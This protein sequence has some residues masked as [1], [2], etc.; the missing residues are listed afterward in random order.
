MKSPFWILILILLTLAIFGCAPLQPAESQDESPQEPKEVPMQELTPQNVLPQPTSNGSSDF[1]SSPIQKFID[2]A[3]NDLGKTL[4]IP[5]DQISVLDT[6]EIIWPNDALGCP[7]P[8]KTYS[9]GKVPG[10]QINLE[11]NNQQYEYHTDLNGKVL[12]CVVP[13]LEENNSSSS[14]SDP[15]I[16][17]PIK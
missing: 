1:S 8:G 6:R 14:S 15:N 7:A 10:Y 11:A 16:G 13:S 9:Q 4:A 2:L 17:V 5:A 3:R 12:L